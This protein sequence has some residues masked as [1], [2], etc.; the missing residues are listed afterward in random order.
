MHQRPACPS[1]G[2]PA[3][4]TETSMCDCGRVRRLGCRQCG[5]WSLGTEI[6]PVDSKRT[7]TVSSTLSRD[8]SG[9]FARS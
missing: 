1:C 4:V 6:I 7:R 2:K 3:A 5:Q 8:S 9:R